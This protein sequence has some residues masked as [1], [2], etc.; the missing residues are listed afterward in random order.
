MGWRPF[1]DDLAPPRRHS[2]T[3]LPGLYAELEA[4]RRKLV[5]GWY[6]TRPGRRPV[7]LRRHERMVRRLATLLS[8]IE[9]TERSELARKASEEDEEKAA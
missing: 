2:A 8:D 9:A 1:K 4:G 5:L 6:A 3:A 7:Y